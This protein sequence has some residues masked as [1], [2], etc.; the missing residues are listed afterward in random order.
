MCFV[1]SNV[2]DLGKCNWDGDV[3]VQQPIVP[4]GRKVVG[5]RSRRSYDIDVREYLTSSSTTG[6]CG[7]S[8][9]LQ[10]GEVSTSSS[11]G[12]G[13]VSTQSSLERCICPLSKKPSAA[14]KGSLPG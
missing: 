12:N 14:F 4:S 13:P 8:R 1:P 11:V 2:M 9:A 3:I 6:I 5:V 7:Q 10:N